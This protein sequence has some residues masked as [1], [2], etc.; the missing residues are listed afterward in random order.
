MGNP[1]LD[2]VVQREH[3]QALLIVAALVW[4]VAVVAWLR[5]PAKVEGNAGHEASGPAARSSHILLAGLGPL[6]VGLWF[7]YN[8]LMDRFGLD[9]VLALGL[10]LAIFLAVGLLAGWLI[11][12]RSTG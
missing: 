3:F 11:G 5:R 12:R 9:S 6:V 10:N 1:L 2:W 4:V 7:V 8:A